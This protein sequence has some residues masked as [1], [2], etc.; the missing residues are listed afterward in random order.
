MT[1]I[2]AAVSPNASN[3]EETLSTL[4]YVCRAKNILNR[5]EV[6]TSTDERIVSYLQ[7]EIKQLRNQLNK[8]HRL[9]EENARLRE[10]VREREKL[11]AQLMMP[12]DE[13]RE[14]TLETLVSMEYVANSRD[15]STS[16]KRRKDRDRV[17]DIEAMLAINNS[18]NSTSNDN[19]NNMSYV[20][21]DAKTK[22]EHML[23][24][25]QTRVGTKN[26]D[27][28]QHIIL[29]SAE[30]IL[31]EHCVF[32][33]ES[34]RVTVFSAPDAFV[35]VDGTKITD[36]L[37]PTPLSHGMMIT[38]GSSYVFEFVVRDVNTSPSPSSSRQEQP[39]DDTKTTTITTDEA[40]NDKNDDDVE[41]LRSSYESLQ[42]RFRNMSQKHAATIARSNLSRSRESDVARHLREEL[43][44]LRENENEL[45]L[46]K[47]RELNQKLSEALSERD[48]ALLEMKDHRRE[49][50]DVQ[51]QQYKTNL[52]NEFEIREKTMQGEMSVLTDKLDRFVGEIEQMQVSEARLQEKNLRLEC[53]IAAAQEKSSGSDIREEEHDDDDDE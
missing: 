10:A 38:F 53:M 16:P 7:E 33:V 40:D 35:F 8:S 12:W 41:L 17:R 39:K 18:S 47:E 43:S 23:R 3:Y 24:I 13:R 49:G 6:N 32:V 34:N 9:D 29:E 46:K 2:L 21:I 30:D 5:A 22:E 14:R 15:S 31:P 20:L 26:A 25:P 28:P 36:S 19:S 4:K 1:I 51:R 37:E 48:A 52:M 42:I 27:V 11:I 50:L 44:E 45:M